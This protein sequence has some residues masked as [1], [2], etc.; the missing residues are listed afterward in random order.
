MTEQVHIR[1]K[2]LRK[3][4]PQAARMAVVEYL[5]TAQATKTE[6]ARVFGVERS[7]IYDILRK[8]KEGDLKDRSKAPG[9]VAN[10]TPIEIEAKVLAA[11]KKTALGPKRLTIYL[12]KKYG[13]RIAYGTVRGIIR[14]NKR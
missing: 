5:S 11:K 7:V 14:R 13:I 10:K 12:Q 6:T 2:A 9:R 3:I 1:Y 4:S 8:K